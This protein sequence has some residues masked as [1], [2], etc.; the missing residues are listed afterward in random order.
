MMILNTRRTLAALLLALGTLHSAIAQPPAVGQR[1]SGPWVFGIQGGAVHQFS[2]N[3]GDTGEF[4][5][6]SWFIQPGV[7]YAWSR[8]TSA[9]IAIGY[10]E[11]NYDFKNGATL[12]GGKPWDRIR[13]ARVSFPIRFGMTETINGIVIP[14]V[15]WNAESGASM[16]DGRTEGVLA[17]FIWRYSDSF[18][19]G[20]GFGPFTE[21]DDDTN[22]FPIILLDWDINDKLNLGTGSGL[23]ATQGPGLVLTYKATPTLD[24]GLGGRVERLKFKLDDRGPA[25]AGIGHEESFHGG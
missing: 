5:S 1:P 22:V 6:T 20:P 2:S 19:I 13:D 14:S 3:L 4:S 17:G 16:D 8:R 10:G 25:P 24:I 12:G 15:R 7:T 18:S 9:G 11:S 23:A 21:I